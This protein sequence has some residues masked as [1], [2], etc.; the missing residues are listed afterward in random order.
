MSTEHEE[1]N[2]KR[3]RHEAEPEE[4]QSESEV[5]SEEEAEDEDEEDNTSDEE[6]EEEDEETRQGNMPFFQAILDGNLRFVIDA[7]ANGRIHSRTLSP[8]K[9]TVLYV[10]CRKG[11]A[12]IVEFLLTDIQDWRIDL[13]HGEQRRTAL[14]AACC[15]DFAL[16]IKIRI[17]DLLLD[18]GA[19]INA[20][21]C[22]NDTA[23]MRAVMKNDVALAEVLLSRGARV[24]L[25]RDG[26]NNAMHYVQSIEMLRLLHGAG[27]DI[28]VRNHAGETPLYIAVEK[29]MV[30]IVRTLLELGA[31]VHMADQHGLTPLMRA[32]LDEETPMRIIELL[33]IHR[34]SSTLYS[35][36]GFTAMH[37]ALIHNSRA[38][39]YFLNC[40]MSPVVMT[41]EAV[42]RSLHRIA[43]ERGYNVQMLNTLQFLE[44]MHREIVQGNVQFV[45]ETILQKPAKVPPLLYILRFSKPKLVEL[46]ELLLQKLQLMVN[47]FACFFDETVDDETSMQTEVE[48]PVAEAIAEAGVPLLAKSRKELKCVYELIT[49]RIKRLQS[50]TATVFYNS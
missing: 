43:L 4:N 24:I 10:A 15:A 40:G 12:D 8:S 28:N 17:I 1:N 2:P 37:L 9:Y 3:Q 48:G 6:D 47:M 44:K 50:G 42:P 20:R 26:G 19:N 16:D 49:K 7:V 30:C 45:L 14:H 21:L 23:L 18:R 22:F 35:A 27:G 33:V 25:T 29:T 34:S 41:R 38:F 46:R 31:D 32:V 13:K 36:N 39:V 5:E 11:L